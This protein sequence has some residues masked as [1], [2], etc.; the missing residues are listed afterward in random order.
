MEESSINEYS[1]QMNL[2]IL[3]LEKTDFGGYICT[4][5]NALGKAEGVVRLQGKICNFFNEHIT[6]K[7]CPF[8]IHFWMY[9]CNLT[10][11]YP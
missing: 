9:N 5:S 10:D 1:L 7:T 8:D 4:S 6:T 11:T 2:T 3:D